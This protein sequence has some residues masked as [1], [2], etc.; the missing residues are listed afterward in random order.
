MIIFA[1]L[2]INIICSWIPS[3]P[4]EIQDLLRSCSV[5]ID[6]VF[7]L[8][9]LAASFCYSRFRVINVE[10]SLLVQMKLFGYSFLLVITGL[11]K[12]L[13]FSWMILKYLLNAL[14]SNYFSSDFIF[15]SVGS[16]F[17]ITFG[18]SSIEEY[19]HNRQLCWT[20]NFQR[21]AANFVNPSIE[22]AL[23]VQFMINSK[24]IFR[25]RHISFI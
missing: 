11:M 9:I 12:R 25:K 1:E 6:F 2:A 16:I 13:G 22:N 20:A 18:L 4:E 7:K 21:P 24:F 23:V 17:L 15:S 14:R 3:C 8:F 10:K 5:V 19:S